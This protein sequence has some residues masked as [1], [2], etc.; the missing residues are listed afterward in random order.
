MRTEDI[1]TGTPDT[2]KD[3][4]GAV[5]GAPAT[6]VGF[7]AAQ[8]RALRGELSRAAFARRVGVTALTVYRWELPDSASEARRPRGRVL[9]RLR[10]YVAAPL[11][12]AS[13]SARS[14]PKQTALQPMAAEIE[15][16]EYERLLPVLERVAKGEMRR[17]ENDLLQLLASGELRTRAARALATQ[18]LARVCVLARGDGRAAFS[19]LLPLL[20]ELEQ[21]ALPPPVALALHLTAALVFASPDGRL[22]DAGK[23]MVHADHAERLLDAH[24][25]AEDRLLLWISQFAVAFILNDRQL[26]ERISSR[27]SEVLQGHEQPVPRAIAL[28]ATAID[29][30]LNGRSGLASRRL[31]ELAQF[32]EA[33]DLTLFRARA[34]S[35]LADTMLEEAADPREVLSL[36]ERARRLAQEHRHG[37]SIQGLVAIWAE[38]EAL[39]R[40]GRFAEAEERLLQAFTQSEELVWTPIAVALSLARLYAFMG[41]SQQLRVLA[42]R[43]SR[44]ASPVQRAITHA[45]ATCFRALAGLLE[46]ADPRAA[47]ETLDRVDQLHYDGASWGFLARSCGLLH[48]SARVLFGE[49]DSAQTALGRLERVLD[50]A[51]SAFANVQLQHHKG[52]LLCRQGRVQEGRKA[53]EGSLASFELAGLVPEAAC[54]RALLAELAERFDEPD[55]ALL[56]ERSRNELARIGISVPAV[57]RFTSSPEPALLAANRQLDPGEV[58][59]LIVPIQRL[60]VR[61]MSPAKIQRELVAVLEVLFPSASIRLE[62]I[63]SKGAA[64]LLAQVEAAT[65][66]KQI[67]L[68]LGDGSGR[69]LRVTVSGA[70]PENAQHVL[71]SVGSVASLALE[72]ATLRGFAEQR[73][74]NGIDSD[75]VLEL[76]GFVAAS[77]AMRALKQDLGRLSRSRS[78]VIVSGESGSGKEIVARALHDLSARAAQPFVAF[79]CAAVPFDL[80]E[81]QLFGYKRGAYTGATSDSP[82]VIRSARG[83]TLFLDEVGELPLDVQPKLLR[84]LENG[85]IFPLGERRAV[86][87]DVRVIAATHRDLEVLVREGLFREDLFYRLQVVPVRIPPLRERREDVVALARHFLRRLTPPDHEPPVLSPDAIATLL[88]HDWPGN[89]RELRNVIERSLAFAPVP[90]VLD[91]SHLRVP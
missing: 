81:G 88:A 62:E 64:L 38:G 48:L 43:M 82:G 75:R 11:R 55:A 51:P 18:A 31:E 6:S 44:Y 77:A 2:T 36:T 25:S 10:A 39:L 87:V 86:Q 78:T 16:G 1:Q 22:F 12:A 80:F 24:G 76:P 73:G 40:M 3:A 34:L 37:I 14:R 91:G 59:R 84:F 72:V 15:R 17:A 58:A 56:R 52:L 35:H 71:T 57:L 29:A 83:G 66:G 41:R 79:N 23:V 60:S 74:P 45:E 89:V 27:G 65:G 54:A 67:S 63:D 5:S 28:Y 61:G 26:F 8:I 9:S 46:G 19:M 4:T 21:T 42:D 47:F 33:H 7:S 50:V 53:I 30:F 20:H 68:E 69:R 70:L 49:L 13:E 90:N 85:E 32:S